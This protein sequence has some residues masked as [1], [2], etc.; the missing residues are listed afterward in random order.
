MKWIATSPIYCT[1]QGKPFLIKNK[2]EIDFSKMEVLAKEVQNKMS[3]IDFEN[4]VVTEKK[5]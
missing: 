5:R 3:K 4:I 2:P 1:I